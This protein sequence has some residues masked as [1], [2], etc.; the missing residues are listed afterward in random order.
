[1][2]DEQPEVV[3]DI[4]MYSALDRTREE[5]ATAVNERHGT[6]LSKRIVGNVINE[7]EK[8]ANNGDAR[9]VF[10]RAIGRGIGAEMGFQMGESI[11]Q[12]ID[13]FTT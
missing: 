4:L 12:A 7:H 2:A 9:A 11:D 3:A 8:M 10:Y 6:D 5:I 1:M 13:Q